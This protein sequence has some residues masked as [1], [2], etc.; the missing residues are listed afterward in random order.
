MVSLQHAHGLVF[1]TLVADCEGC[2]C[3]FAEENPCFVFHQLRNIMFEA[4]LPKTC[5][6]AALR[7]RL[8]AVGF[9]PVVGG[10]VS[11][12]RRAAGVCQNDLL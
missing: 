11:F 6:Y 7:R 5:D 8:R 2:L 12:W 4:D 9:R 10:F 1:D 3:A